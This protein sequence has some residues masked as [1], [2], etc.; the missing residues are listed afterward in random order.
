[1]AGGGRRGRS[2]YGSS[3][4]SKL[5]I[6]RSKGS[7]LPGCNFHSRIYDLA[8]RGLYCI[9]TTPLTSP[10]K[11]YCKSHPPSSPQCHHTPSHADASVHTN[12]LA[13]PSFPFSFCTCLLWL[14]RNNPLPSTRSCFFPFWCCCIKKGI[15]AVSSPPA[16][17]L[18][19]HSSV[20]MSPFRTTTL[21]F[22]R[23]RLFFCFVVV[24]IFNT[25]VEM[26]SYFSAADRYPVYWSVFAILFFSFFFYIFYTQW[27]S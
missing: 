6:R 14:P 12:A 22:K 4:G 24:I 15:S 8:S 21:F 5:V 16:G 2:S 23:W 27:Y 19:H 25:F 1:M 11:G 9:E 20:I 3:K 7:K 26:T 18:Q 10:A 17:L 13:D